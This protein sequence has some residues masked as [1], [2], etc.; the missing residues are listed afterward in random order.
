MA[1]SDTHKFEAKFRDSLVSLLNDCSEDN[2]ANNLSIVIEMFI[3][4]HPHSVTS[5]DSAWIQALAK[6]GFDEAMVPNTHISILPRISYDKPSESIWQRIY[7]K[8]KFVTVHY[9]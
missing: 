6:D 5:K 4:L 8:F 2:Y 7:D 9:G 1:Y 3:R